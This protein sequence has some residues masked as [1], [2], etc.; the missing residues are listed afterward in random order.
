MKEGRGPWIIICAAIS[1][2]VECCK[3]AAFE[4]CKVGGFALVVAHRT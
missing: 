4:S 1:F 2:D 3:N